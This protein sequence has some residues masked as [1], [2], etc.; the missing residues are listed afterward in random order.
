M[1]PLIEPWLVKS[2]TPNL[3]ISGGGSQLGVDGP[4]T[5]DNSAPSYHSPAF[6]VPT[7]LRGPPA[8]VG[9]SAPHPAAASPP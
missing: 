9:R 4:F 8:A 7:R 2:R 6:P 1:P 3:P 5:R